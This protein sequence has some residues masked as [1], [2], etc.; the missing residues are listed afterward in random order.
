MTGGKFCDV[1]QSNRWHISYNNYWALG[2][3]D[4]C[5]SAYYILLWVFA[6]G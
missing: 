1:I 4:D 2:N 3:A 6:E 5:I